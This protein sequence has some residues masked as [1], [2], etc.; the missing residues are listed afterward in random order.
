MR[1][2]RFL[3]HSW[4]ILVLS[5]AAWAGVIG[6][7]DVRIG[8]DTGARSAIFDFDPDTGN[9]YAVVVWEESWTFNISTDGG[10]TWSS[11]YR[12][13]ATQGIASIDM[14]VGDSYVYV[15]YVANHTADE[16]LM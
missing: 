2:Q 9:Y 11:F 3:I 6:G 14:A 13:T 8:T 7:P 12:S 15:G 10:T 4:L 1:I 5:T 16:A